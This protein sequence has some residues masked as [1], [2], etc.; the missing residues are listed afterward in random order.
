MV[1]R[2]KLL[3]SQSGY[4]IS[5]LGDQNYLDFWPKFQSHFV[6]QKT[7]D[8]FLIFLR[9]KNINLGDHFFVKKVF[10]LSDNIFSKIVPNFS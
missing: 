5:T 7:R 1:T 2:R 10:F 8:F 6:C 9:F 3:N 4:R